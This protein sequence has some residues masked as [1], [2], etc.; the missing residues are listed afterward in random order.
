MGEKIMQN[1]KFRMQNGGHRILILHFAF[2]IL[3]LKNTFL[4][5]FLFG[6]WGWGGVQQV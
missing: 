3:N 2:Y 1:A 4:G 6:E 5:D